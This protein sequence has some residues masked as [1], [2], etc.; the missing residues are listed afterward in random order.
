MADLDTRR[1][2]LQGYLAR[3]RAFQ[4]RM[5]R[6]GL[7]AVA[8]AFALLV[9]GAGTTVFW[10]VLG[11]SLLVAGCGVWITQSHIADFEHQLRE[12]ERRRRDPAA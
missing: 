12:L 8:V 10:T 7:V 5:A 2:T 6:A 3:S 1:S 11:L 4:R 9:G